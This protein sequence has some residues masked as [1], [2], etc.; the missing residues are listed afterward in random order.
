M[1]TGNQT[2]LFYFLARIL[3]ILTRIFTSSFSR[4]IPHY[5]LLPNL[6][7]MF[8]PKFFWRALVLFTEH[9]EESYLIGEP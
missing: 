3:T 1:L 6:F 2:L 7:Q 9:F 4:K 8:H 5:S